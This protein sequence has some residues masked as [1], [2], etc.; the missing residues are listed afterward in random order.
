MPKPL[1]NKLEFE[2]PRIYQ[3]CAETDF[4]TRKAKVNKESGRRKAK[5][6]TLGT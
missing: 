6:H 2:I 1:K 4:K 5:W 3:G